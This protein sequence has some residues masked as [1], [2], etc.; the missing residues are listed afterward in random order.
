MNKSI[1]AEIQSAIC[2]DAKRAHI[3]GH[4]CVQPV[5]RLLDVEKWD[6]IIQ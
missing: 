2:A 3:K 4:V 1:N 5:I 6:K